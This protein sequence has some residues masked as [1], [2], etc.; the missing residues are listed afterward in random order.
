MMATRSVRATPYWPSAKK[1][2]RLTG[3]SCRRNRC[4]SLRQSARPAAQRTQPPA[5]WGAGRKKQAAR[6]CAPNVSAVVQYLALPSSSCCQLPSPPVTEISSSRSISSIVA[7]QDRV[8][9]LRKRVVSKASPVDRQE[10]QTLPQR[11]CT[12]QNTARCSL[13]NISVSFKLL[14]Y[15]PDPIEEV[16]KRSFF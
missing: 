12:V 3:S 14:P 4:K 5:L 1:A 6:A 10:P 8:L 13:L 7:A 2:S 16:S 9:C 15:R 11:I